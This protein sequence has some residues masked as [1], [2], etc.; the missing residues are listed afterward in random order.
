MDW[1]SRDVIIGTSTSVAGAVLM[2]ITQSIFWKLRESSGGYTGPWR[3]NI[4]DEQGNIVKR[5]Q[6]DLRQRGELLYGTIK[7]VFPDEQ[8]HRRW[9]CYGRIRGSDFFA[10]FWSMNVSVRSYGCWY[11]RQVSDN[12][13]SGYYFRLSDQGA[14]VTGIPL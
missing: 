6:I 11:V 3:Q 9:K 14:H 1:L 8:A 10:I 7:R 5:D 2:L 13:F 12:K 4:F